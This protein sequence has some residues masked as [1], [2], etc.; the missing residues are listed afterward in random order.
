MASIDAFP[1]SDVIEVIRK[2]NDRL[3]DRRGRLF[4]QADTLLDVEKARTLAAA[5][6]WIDVL[7]TAEVKMEPGNEFNLPELYWMIK[8][9]VHSFKIQPATEKWLT[10]TQREMKMMMA[11]EA[12]LDRYASRAK[13]DTARPKTNWKNGKKK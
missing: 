5:A 1:I 7:I 13:T 9:K 6:M 8:E 12:H 2:V 11:I 3:W 4:E 10:L